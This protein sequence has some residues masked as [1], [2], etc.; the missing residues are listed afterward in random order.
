M[1]LECLK[2]YKNIFHSNVYLNRKRGGAFASE[3]GARIKTQRPSFGSK[4]NSEDGFDFNSV[5]NSTPKINFSDSDKSAEYNEED[6]D[7]DDEDFSDI[8]VA[9]VLYGYDPS[10]MSPNEYPE[11]ELSLSAGEFVYIFGEPDIDGFYTA[12]LMSGQRGLVPSNFIQI[13]DLDEKKTQQMRRISLAN[14]PS[15][16][17]IMVS[18]PTSNYEANPPSQIEVNMIGSR[19]I[20]LTWEPPVGFIPILGYRIFLNAQEFK[21]RL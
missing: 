7:D 17:N 9:L 11:D 2:I 16:A 13:V 19:T 15:H 8:S 18:A 12:E 10:T 20:E 21:V 14:A 4:P 6:E 1:C 5:L 3:L